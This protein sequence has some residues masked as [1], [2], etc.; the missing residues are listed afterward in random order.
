MFYRL[1]LPANPL[2]HLFSGRFRIQEWSKI[3]KGI[4][5]KPRPRSLKGPFRICF[6]HWAASKKELEKSG[7]STPAAISGQPPPHFSART[8]LPMSRRTWQ[9]DLSGNHD[10]TTYY[11]AIL[12][13]F[14]FSS[15][16][17][18]RLLVKK[19]GD[20]W[21]FWIC[22]PTEKT[23]QNFLEGTPSIT[24]QRYRPN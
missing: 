17:L 21:F 10:F 9:Q 5:E 3:S 6:C 11:R 4:S 24:V 13:Y 2:K 18:Q 1:S 16:G 12:P 15:S 19:S 14:P 20:Q 8:R 23:I 7:D 22:S